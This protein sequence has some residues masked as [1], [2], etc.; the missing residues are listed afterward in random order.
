[1]KHVLLP[2]LETF[3]PA[4]LREGRAAYAVTRNATL[5][6]AGDAILKAGGTYSHA[7]PPEPIRFKDGFVVFPRDWPKD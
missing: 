3:T 5:R 6:E 1:M 7:E 2:A 4:D